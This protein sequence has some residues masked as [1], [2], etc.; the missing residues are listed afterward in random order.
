MSVL[1]VNNVLTFLLTHLHVGMDLYHLA[2]K[3]FQAKNILIFDMYLQVVKCFIG[4]KKNCFCV[5]SLEFTLNVNV[6]LLFRHI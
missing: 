1:K 3:F 6:N 2:N 4:V 5:K